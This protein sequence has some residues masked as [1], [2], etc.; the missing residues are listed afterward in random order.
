MIRLYSHWRSSA[1]YR[2]RVGLHLKKLQFET[3]AVDLARPPDERDPH[4]PALNPQGLVPTLVIDGV[5]IGQSLAILEYLDERYPDPPLLPGDALQRARARELALTI[6]ADVHPLNN[7]RVLRYLENELHTGDAARQAWYHHWL[8]IGLGAAER[9]VDSRGPFALGANLGLADLF[10]VPQ[11]YNARRFG[12][13]LQA[14]PRLRRIDAACAPLEAFA[15]ALPER[16]PD[17]PAAVS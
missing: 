5:A 6:A 2:V 1:A 14:Y 12:F 7:L 11:L 15:R 9:L 16:Q 3:M 8:R 4:Y 13:S 10:I 17:A